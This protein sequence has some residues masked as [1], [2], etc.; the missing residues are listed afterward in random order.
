MLTEIIF[1]TSK[2]LIMPQNIHRNDI[3][4]NITLDT[5]SKNGSIETG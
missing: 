4:Q 1:L 3:L 2:Q 5:K